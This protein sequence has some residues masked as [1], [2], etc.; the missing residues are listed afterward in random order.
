[1]AEDI[2]KLFESV[3]KTP[4]NDGRVIYKIKNIDYNSRP[5]VKLFSLSSPEA[6][7][8]FLKELG[9]K[10]KRIKNKWKRVEKENAHKIIDYLLSRDMA[11]DFELDTKPMA[12]RLSSYFFDQFTPEAQFYTNGEF[13]EE[14]GFFALGSWISI[15]NSVFDTG[16]LVVDQR[17]IGILWA[18]DND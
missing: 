14:R 12:N 6:K 13:N 5:F 9:L 16:V 15:T 2:K 7:E 10:N 3:I 8:K 4:R 17:K 11:Y 1:M 18:E